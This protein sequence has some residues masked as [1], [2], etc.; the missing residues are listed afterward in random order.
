MDPLSF[1]LCWS[2]VF[3]L[4]VLAVILK[5][6]ALEMSVYGTVFALV[7][8]TVFFATPV[9]VALL[10]ALDGLLTTTPLV[11]V[12]FAGI[13]LSSLLMASG[14]LKRI[15]DWFMGGVRDGFHRSLLITLGVGNFME[16]A[17][18]IAEPVVAPM[19]AAAGVAP[20]GAAALSIVGYAGLMT[21]EMAGIFITVLALITELPLAQ[22]GLA[23]A[24]LSIP[25]TLSMA[26]VV[27]FFLGRPLPGPGRWLLVLACGALLGFAAL[28]VVAWLAVSIAGMVAGL[29]LILALV[30]VGSGRLPLNRRVLMDLAPFLF[31]L[32]VLLL[33]NAVG[34]LKGLVF[35]RLS[36]K[37]SLIPVHVITLRPLYSAYLYLALAALLA[38]K[39]FG[40]KGEMLRQILASG[41]AKAVRASAAMLLFGAMGQV[42]AYSGYGPG[43]AQMNQASNIPWIM[44]QGLIHYTHSLYPLF[45]PFLGWVG[46]FLTG[47]GVASLMLFGKLQ[48]QGGELLGQSPTWLASGLAVGASLGSISSPF[49]I[50]LAAPMCGALGQEG[51]IL[52]YTIPLGVAASLLV[53]LVLWLVI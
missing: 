46:T 51:A 38:I 16:G 19:L 13:M 1:L 30:L 4:I 17:G 22:L 6:P 52:R 42:I 40:F 34:P 43:F 21:L 20:R 26:A 23:S 10:S 25:A 33:V 36:F 11:L 39:I 8:V 45:T 29:A 15:V 9:Q 2:P 48:V 27:P 44:A 50:A 28:A 5:R 41:A 3:L 32:A 53:G 24:W 31:L 12:I 7:L 49:K 14:S 35:E 18:V 47:Y 37:V